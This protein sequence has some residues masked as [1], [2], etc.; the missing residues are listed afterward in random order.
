MYFLQVLG[1]Y[2]VPAGTV[3]LRV[4]SSIART[5]ANFPQPDTF[6]PERWL[7]GDSQRHTAD[8]F[9]NLP[10]GHGTRSDAGFT[11]LCNILYIYCRACV[12][13]R[14]ARLELQVVAATL[15]QRYKLE[16]SGPPVETT[17]R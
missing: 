2:L 9:A 13:Q 8:P 6:L 12:G 7:R 1:G 15:V 5:A 17:T 10:F 14:F 4:G 11:C 16:Y 3:V